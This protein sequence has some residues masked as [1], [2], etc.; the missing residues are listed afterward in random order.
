MKVHVKTRHHTQYYTSVDKN[1][2]KVRMCC[3]RIQTKSHTNT[4]AKVSTDTTEMYNNYA[5]VSA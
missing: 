2:M 4:E 3:K 5:R 1:A